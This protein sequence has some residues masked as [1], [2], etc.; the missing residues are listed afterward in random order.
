MFVLQLSTSD[1]TR[2]HTRQ[3]WIKRIRDISYRSPEQLYK[4][5][6]EIIQKDA[7]TF[8]NQPTKRL[9]IYIGLLENDHNQIRYV[10]TT[11]DQIDL[12]LDRTLQ[13]GQGIS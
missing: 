11:D 4:E 3:Q 9:S 2:V 6:T 12:L 5:I 10:A 13:R 8:G 7:D 1:R